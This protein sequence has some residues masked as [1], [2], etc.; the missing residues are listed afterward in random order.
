MNFNTRVRVE[1]KV[2]TTDPIYGTE[3]ISYEL[4]GLAWAEV[5]DKLPSRD[6]ALM[7]VIAMSS[8]RAR[9]RLRYRTD[10]DS[11]MRFIIMRPE[12]TIWGII[13][14]PATIGAKEGIEFLIEK[15]SS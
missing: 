4:L 11:S 8:I 9:L 12:S 14:G 7:D 2:T 1:K 10:L 3:V 6:E 13:G 5:Q 15:K